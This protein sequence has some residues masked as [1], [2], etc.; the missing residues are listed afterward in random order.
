MAKLKNQL[1][2]CRRE[3]WALAV[4][5]AVACGGFYVVGI[6]PA[7]L[8]SSVVRTRLVA[9]QAELQ[10]ARERI[11]GLPEIEQETEALRQ[12]VEHF[13]KTVPDANDLPQAIAD[14]TQ[15]GRESSVL[16]LQWRSDA[17]PRRTEQY[18]ELPIQFTFGGDFNGVF[19]FLHRTEEMQ[20]LTRVKKLDIKA[21]P[22]GGGLVDVQLTMNLYF[23]EE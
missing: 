21:R 17:K 23:T 10:L 19:D 18:T 22:G 12:Q 16:D 15:F 11:K 8:R 2:W 20:R 6:R 9:Q 7:S 13:Q 3:Q 4:A 14:V 1:V 5:L